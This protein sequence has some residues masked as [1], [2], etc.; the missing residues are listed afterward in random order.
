MYKPVYKRVYKMSFLSY[1]WSPQTSLNT[2]PVIIN[3]IAGEIL[4]FN[5]NSLRK[6]ETKESTNTNTNMNEFMRQRE[7]ILK[8]GNSFILVETKE[9]TNM[10]E[11][12]RQREHILKNGNS[13][14]VNHDKELAELDQYSHMYLM[15]YLQSS[16][17]MQKRNEYDKK[18]TEFCQ[19]IT[20]YYQTLLNVEEQE[21][22]DML[23]ALFD[24]IDKS[25][26]IL[27]KKYKLVKE[28]NGY[29]M[30]KRE[31][32]TSLVRQFQYVMTSQGKDVFTE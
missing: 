6:V 12:M 19:E 3:D 21:R 16:E 15:S 14:S 22:E 27:K 5:I 26:E 31:N 29:T 17:I 10:N 30:S 32:Y 1:L 23:N 13:I 8:N 2:E 20:K 25:K 28:Y 11:F 18:L 7:H 24:T 4:K 9:S